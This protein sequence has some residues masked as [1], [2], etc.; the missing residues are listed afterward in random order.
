[1][2]NIKLK[3]R[4]ADKDPI[5][6]EVDRGKVI[7]NR[8]FA[9]IAKGSHDGFNTIRKDLLDTFYYLPENL[10]FND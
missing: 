8:G 9:I 2:A 7:I 5:Y 6:L 10:Q 3:H 4:R 1:M